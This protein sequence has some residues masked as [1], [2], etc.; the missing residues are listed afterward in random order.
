MQ[1]IVSLL[2]LLCL[3][4]PRVAQSAAL[5]RGV[6]ITDPLALRE[7]DVRD[8]LIPGITSTGFGLGRMLDAKTLLRPQMSNEELFALPSMWS[9]RKALDREFDRYVTSH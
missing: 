8:Y 4:V 5:E 9:V 1:F 6:A 3:M 7:L 2:I